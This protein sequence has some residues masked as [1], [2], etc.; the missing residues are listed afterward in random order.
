MQDEALL[1]LIILLV[2]LIITLLIWRAVWLAFWRR[3]DDLV[4]RQKRDR[5]LETDRI[6]NKLDALHLAVRQLDEDYVPDED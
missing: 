3:A 4:E 5:K 6:I 1:R 2:A